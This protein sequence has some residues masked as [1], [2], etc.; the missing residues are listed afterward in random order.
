M[1]DF[2]LSVFQRMY[3]WSAAHELDKQ[4]SLLSATLWL[5][6]LQLV[7]LLT[8][9]NLI[10]S[11]GLPMPS[12]SG[13]HTLVVGAVLLAANYLFTL[14]YAGDIREPPRHKSLA[15]WY[16]ALSALAFAATFIAFM[17]VSKTK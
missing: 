17:A 14:K 6:V 1:K 12:I 15:T 4:P 9:Y 13:V 7:N 3:V 2:Y 10:A 11:L 16:V 8:A 5:S